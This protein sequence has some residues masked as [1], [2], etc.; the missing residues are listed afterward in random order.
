[1]IW[2]RD[3]KDICVFVLLHLFVTIPEGCI[4]AVGPSFYFHHHTGHILSTRSA[5]MERL[6]HIA[7][8]GPSSLNT[9]ILPCLKRVEALS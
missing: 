6:I 4:D 8:T 7:R 9:E 5:F 3:K 2:K 1:M